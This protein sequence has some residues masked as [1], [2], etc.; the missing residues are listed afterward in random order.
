MKCFT[1]CSLLLPG[2]HVCCLH[3][4]HRFQPILN[5]IPY[6]KKLTPGGDSYSASAVFPRVCSMCT[7][8]FGD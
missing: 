2:L 6:H 3:F 7:V 8:S 5:S 1:S 4:K